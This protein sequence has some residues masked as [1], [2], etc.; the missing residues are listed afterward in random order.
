MTKIEELNSNE[1]AL[2]SISWLIDSEFF[3]NLGTIRIFLRLVY[4]VEY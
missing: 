4:H 1:Q 2:S 3:L